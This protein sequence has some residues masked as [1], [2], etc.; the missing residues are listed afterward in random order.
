MQH[1]IERYDNHM[2]KPFV[3]FNALA[4]TYQQNYRSLMLET[5]QK[6]QYYY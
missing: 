2:I 3:S 1:T 5:T 4:I 6:L